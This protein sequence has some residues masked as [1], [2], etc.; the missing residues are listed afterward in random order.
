MTNTIILKKY[1]PGIAAGAGAG[2]AAEVGTQDA[3][4]SKSGVGCLNASSGDPI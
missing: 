1:S 2:E 3:M 4:Q